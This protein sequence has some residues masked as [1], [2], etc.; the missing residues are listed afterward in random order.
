[1]NQ[2]FE[3]LDFIEN[4]LYEQIIED[5]AKQKFTIIDNFFF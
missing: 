3:A 1:M 4:P 2:I 5:I